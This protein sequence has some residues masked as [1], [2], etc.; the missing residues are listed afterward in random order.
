MQSRWAVRLNLIVNV[1]IV[2]AAA[3]VVLHPRGPLIPRVE[4]WKQ[5][6][7]V[8]NVLAGTWPQLISSSSQ[9][10]Q[11]PDTSGRV[12]VV[13]S[14]YQCPA[15]RSA[16]ERLPELMEEHNFDIVYRHL[17]LT[18]IHPMAEQGARAAICAE[19]QGRFFE[20]HNFLFENEEWADEGDWGAVATA[21]ELP[22]SAS[23]MNCLRHESTT[24]RLNQ[25]VAY[26]KQLG[27]SATPSFV[28]AR[29]VQKGLPDAERLLRLL[30]G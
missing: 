9:V 14:D 19:S 8:R 28:G 3:I 11:A 25:D 1:G 6:I 7:A 15:C 12:L 27:L 4:E 22:D 30:D 23:F 26:A 13:F 5:S 24:R 29:G 16:E 18:R 17:P 2:V 10:R 20:M 21:V